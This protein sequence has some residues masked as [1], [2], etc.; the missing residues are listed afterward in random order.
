MLDNTLIV[1]TSD[2]KAPLKMTKPD[3]PIHGDLGLGRFA[4]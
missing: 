4:Q 2:N 1:M 3:T